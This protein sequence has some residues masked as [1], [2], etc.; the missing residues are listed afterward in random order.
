MKRDF[1]CQ[2]GL[3][4]AVSSVQLKTFNPKCTIVFQSRD[5]T[6]HRCDFIFY[7]VFMFFLTFFYC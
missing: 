7:A 1:L 5:E 6:N 3:P 2:K 4:V